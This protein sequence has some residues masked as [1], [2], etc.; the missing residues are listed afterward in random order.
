VPPFARAADRAPCSGVAFVGRDAPRLSD[1]ERKLV[2]GDENTEGWSSIPTNQKEYFLRAFLQQRGYHAPTFVVSRETLSVDAGAKSFIRAL[3][4]SGLPAGIDPSK[5]RNIVGSEMTPRALDKVKGALGDVLQEKGFACPEIA[6]SADSVTGKVS[7]AATPGRP[8]FIDAIVPARLKASDPGV[9]GRYEAF[10]RGQPFDMRLLVLTAERTVADSLFVSAYYEVACSTAGAAIIQHVVEGKPRL[11]Q[12]GVGFDTEGYAIGKV[13]WKNSRLDTRGSSAEGAL[14]GSFRQESAEASLR[15]S[16][17]PSS[18]LYLKPRLFYDRENQIQFESVNAE[19]SL[20]PGTSWDGETLRFDFA[21]GP[22]QEF[23]RTVR[24]PG[25]ARDSFQAFKTQWTL[26][27]HLFEYYAGE[28]RAGWRASLDTVSRVAGAD[29]SFT[30]HRFSARGEALWNLGNESPP[31][32][33]AATRW[34]AGTTY[35]NDRAVA[36]KN[37]APDMR[38][39]LGGDSNLRGAALMGLPGDDAGFL[40]TVYDGLE[41][42]LGDVSAHGFQPLV[43]VDGAMGGRADIHLDPDVYWSPGLG[44]RWSLPVGSIRGTAARGLT[45]RRDSQ[46][47]S[48]YPP[49]WQFFLSFGEEF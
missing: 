27:D 19:A 9:F 15:E 33:I 11:Y 12:V 35:V 2:C 34:W 28:P 44:F 21:A 40:T 17:S 6:L 4:V 48:L 45:W 38:F 5:L 7:A 49:H 25:P 36:L 8:G 37:L 30:A 31:M 10:R 23:V 26:T 18:R 41:L 47:A 24:G 39:F 13:Q 20:L 29:S 14:Y 46:A 43:F 16:L 1:V 22:A 42:R 32:V 3:S